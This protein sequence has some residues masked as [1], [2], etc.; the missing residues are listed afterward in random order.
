MHYILLNNLSDL[1]ETP[2]NLTNKFESEL[3]T[4]T[5]TRPST[6]TVVGD[7]TVN[8]GG[9]VIVLNGGIK[10]AG[11]TNQERFI[12]YVSPTQG[13]LNIKHHNWNGVLSEF[14][15][16]ELFYVVDDTVELVRR[17]QFLPYQSATVRAALIDGLN[18]NWAGIELRDPWRVDSQGNQPD[19]FAFY[20]P[21]SNN[22]NGVFQ[23]Q[24]FDIPNSK[25]YSARAG[26]TVITSGGTTGVRVDRIPNLGMA[27]WEG[28]GASVQLAECRRYGALQRAVALVSG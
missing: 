16:S 22:T 1:L 7:T 15:T 12:G 23:N 10:I 25:F 26:D 18:F 4:N 21:S 5:P 2:L 8:S 3:I 20:P 17:A 11:K 24:R 9:T 27:I 19:A 28:T 14:R 13:T 6:L